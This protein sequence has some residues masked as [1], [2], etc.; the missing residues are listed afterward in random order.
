MGKRRG[1]TLTVLVGTDPGEGFE[2]R[3]TMDGYHLPVN[4]NIGTGGR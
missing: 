4:L 3:C 1:R 2:A